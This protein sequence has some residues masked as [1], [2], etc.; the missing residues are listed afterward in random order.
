M[1]NDIL[2]RYVLQLNVLNLSSLEKQLLAKI[3][4]IEDYSK[5]VK[6]LLGSSINEKTKKLIDWV[7][8]KSDGNKIEK[9]LY[10]ESEAKAEGLKKEDL[11]II[12]PDT[13]YLDSKQEETLDFEQADK[14]EGHALVSQ[15]YQLAY[16][17]VIRAMVD[18]VVAINETLDHKPY[19]DFVAPEI[20]VKASVEEDSTVLPIIEAPKSKLAKAIQN[21]DEMPI[22]DVDELNVQMP[23]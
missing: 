13:V 5:E 16:K 4:R 19:G 22:I 6:I 21:S 9:N 2:D 14:T 1:N 12:V 10:K 18:N 15:K 20:T 11:Y 17:S 7:S 8:V 23:F 3:Y